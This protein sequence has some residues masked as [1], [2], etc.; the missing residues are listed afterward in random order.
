MKKILVILLLLPFFVVSQ[1]QTKTNKGSSSSKKPVKVNPKVTALV[2][3][4]YKLYDATEDDKCQEVIKKILA[5]DKKNK[6]AYLLKANLAMF[7]FKF[8][9]M[10]SSLD[11]LYKMYPEQPDLYSNFAMNHLNYLYLS[12]SAKRSMC[13][14]TIRYA[15]RSA[16]GYAALGM[17]AA[18]GGSY[19]EALTC[20]DIAYNKNWK[21]TLSR[22]VL[23]LPYANCL[24]SVG[25]TMGAIKKLDQII[26][27]MSGNDKFNCVYL[28]ARF[29]LESNQTDVKTDLDTLNNYA[30]DKA[31]VM[32]LNA[33]YYS[34]TNRQ[35][36]SCT[37]A[38]KIKKMEG[39]EGFDMS[40]YCTNLDKCFEMKEISKLTYDL[41]GYEFQL[42]ITEFNYP[43]IIRFNWNKSTNFKSGVQESGVVQ[44]AGRALDSAITLVT[45]FNADANVVMDKTISFWMSRVQYN[46]IIAK[47]KVAINQLGTEINGLQLYGHQQ[48]EVKNAMNKSIY[49]DCLMLSDGTNV[50]YFLN[51]PSNPIIV[52]IETEDK[53]IF[54]T[55][56]Q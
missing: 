16:E 31:Q 17:V 9:E 10:W 39:T 28:R 22:V 36:T 24:Y 20:F 54:L 8:D 49:L 46:Q 32:L 21:D 45:E 2:E 33:K 23:D 5:L 38:H 26:P 55:K 34:L 7:A 13:K 40:P 41:D 18:A 35:D 3:E 29:K 53:S 47:G 6:D 1:A 43:E 19:Y 48:I 15:S 42:D 51:D 27:R 52:K 12:D 30:G 56:F 37:I 50:I 11:N 25:D 14:K 4:A 44:I